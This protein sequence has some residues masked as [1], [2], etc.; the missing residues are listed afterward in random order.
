MGDEA[1]EEPRSGAGRATEADRN[2]GGGGGGGGG[3]RGAREEPSRP[4]R[5]P[6]SEDWFEDGGTG[7]GAGGGACSGAGSSR[8]PAEAAEKDSADSEEGA[9][10]DSEG[11]D[12]EGEAGGEG[13][14]RQNEYDV[15]GYDE[16]HKCGVRGHWSVDC[17]APRVYLHCPFGQKDEAKARK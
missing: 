11:S 9:G 4:W 15:R 13:G 1:E 7:G 3:A 5:D 14:R 10:M 6:T 2:G 8:Q 12:A 16:C 17:R